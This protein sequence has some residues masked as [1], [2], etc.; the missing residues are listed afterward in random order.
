MAVN[1]NRMLSNFSGSSVLMP[2]AAFSMTK[3]DRNCMAV[4]DMKRP[5]LTKKLVPIAFILILP[6]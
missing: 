5:M 1:K 2:G 6:P 4:K 3:D